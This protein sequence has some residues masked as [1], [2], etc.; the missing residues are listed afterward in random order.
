[1]R[2]A[3]PPRGG[4]QLPSTS[5]PDLSG[6]V[7]RVSVS[8]AGALAAAAS[9]HPSASSFARPAGSS[10]APRAWGGGGA[11]GTGGRLSPPSAPPSSA[12][13]SW[14]SPSPRAS[15]S[16]PS[17]SVPSASRLSPA[18]SPSAPARPS[19]LRPRELF[20]WRGGA[21]GGQRSEGGASWRDDGLP[22]LSGSPRTPQGLPTRI[23]TN[24]T[25]RLLMS[26]E[27][28][29]R[30]VAARL[31]PLPR[32]PPG[33]QAPRIANPSRQGKGGGAPRRRWPSGRCSGW[34]R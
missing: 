15:R 25:A 6:G 21:R 26:L 32:A 20:P 2:A 22:A 34:G 3:P 17:A 14:T 4:Q 27:K 31:R 16:P 28:L 33:G 8:L 9:S 23:G 24:F 30:K 19:P 13:A 5:G 12:A 10:R 18:R 1:M 11:E 7:A 29:E